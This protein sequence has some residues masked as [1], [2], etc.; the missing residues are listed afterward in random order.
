MSRV[1]KGVFS[2]DVISRWASTFTYKA[3][4]L[5]PKPWGNEGLGMVITSMPAFPTTRAICQILSLGFRVYGL[6]FRVFFFMVRV[7]VPNNHILTPNLYYNYY[8]PDPKY[9]I[10]GYMDP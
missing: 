1:V 7:Q 9:P 8:C 4:T 2:W 10:I 5:N 6:G 3:I